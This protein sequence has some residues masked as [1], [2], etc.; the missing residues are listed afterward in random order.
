[1]KSIE[2]WKMSDGHETIQ[3]INFKKTNC[4]NNLMFFFSQI[5]VFIIDDD[6]EEE[7]KR[8]RVREPVVEGL[9]ELCVFLQEETAEQSLK[10][11]DIYTGWLK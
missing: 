4:A 7:E 9:T 1:M 11:Q 10:L 6:D 8:E 5:T 3:K 2:V